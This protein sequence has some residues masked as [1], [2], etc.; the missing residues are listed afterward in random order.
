MNTKNT[1]RYI[2]G[3]AT[4]PQGDGIKIILHI[5]N[6]AGFWGKGFVLAIS[7]K[8]K[9]PEKQFKAWYKS[10]EGFGL[11]EVQ[12]IKV[13]DDL[14]IGNIIGQHGIKSVNGIPP[15]RYEAVKAGLQKAGH[16]SSGEKSISIH[17]PRIGCGLAGGTWD[18]IE[19]MIIEALTDKG[20]P[21]TVYD[22]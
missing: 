17:M 15:I 5:C 11:G 16:F 14:I 13:A 22:F 10:G 1:I 18:M 3:D 21:V 12:F 19:P 4:S 20:I 9:E 6:D 8:W 7:K 2:Q